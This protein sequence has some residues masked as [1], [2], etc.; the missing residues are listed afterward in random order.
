MMQ[1]ELDFSCAMFDR[2][3]DGKRLFAQLADVAAVMR[4]G[5]WR[6]LAEISAA[7]G[8]PH[9]SVSARLRDLRKPNRGGHAVER[10]YIRDGL[11]AYR[12]VPQ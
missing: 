4:D 8:H 3:R 1:T 11:W 10:K 12:V 6:T 2:Q 5:N 7:T 9:A